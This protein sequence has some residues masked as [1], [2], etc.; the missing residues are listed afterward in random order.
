VTIVV[1]P[2]V[3]ARANGLNFGPL[4]SR[5]REPNIGIY[6]ALYWFYAACVGGLAILGLAV[7]VVELLGSGPQRLGERLLWLAAFTAVAVFLGLRAVPT[8]TRRVFYLYPGGYVVTAASGRIRRAVAWKEVSA[9]EADP[10]A[11]GTTIVKPR[12]RV[13]IIHEKRRP[14]KFVERLHKP[15][16]LEQLLR[17][18]HTEATRARN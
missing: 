10:I 18:L 15:T 14:I 17:Q 5:V 16:N 3:Q 13:R 8:S 11:F 4:T 7:L 9:I 12:Y 6:A 1:P 2:S